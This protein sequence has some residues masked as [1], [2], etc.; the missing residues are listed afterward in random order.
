VP[1]V[2]LQ[3]AVSKA[4]NKEGGRFNYT[5]NV[6]NLGSLNTGE[7]GTAFNVI[8]SDNFPVGVEPTSLYW[9]EPNGATNGEP[10][11]LRTLALLCAV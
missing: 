9:I 8:V 1:D 7:E 4:I 6:N 10:A 5:F 3:K 2:R 11:T